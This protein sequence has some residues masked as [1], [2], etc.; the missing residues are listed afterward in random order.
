[1][2]AGRGDNCKLPFAQICEINKTQLQHTKRRQTRLDNNYCSAPRWTPSA[3]PL[4]LPAMLSFSLWF[5]FY[6]AKRCATPHHTTLQHTIPCHVSS[7]QFPVRRSQFPVCIGLGLR[8]AA[9]ICEIVISISSSNSSMRHAAGSRSNC[10]RR[11]EAQWD[12]LC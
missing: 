8:L 12:K 3:C 5:Y 11:A 9:E 1:M 2:G 7:S 4:P 6:C 10:N